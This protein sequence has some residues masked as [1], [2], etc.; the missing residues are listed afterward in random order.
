MNSFQSR[1]QSSISLIMAEA[2]YLASCSANYESIWLRKLLIGLFDLEMEA[3][4]ILCDNQ[5]CIKMM[6]NPL[7]HDNL[8]HIDIQYHYILYMV[9]RRALNLQYVDTYEWVA[10]VLTKPLSRVKFEYFRDNNVVV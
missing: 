4:V 10:N 3:N 1:K 5:S 9:Q 7:F 2:E 8:K 6:E